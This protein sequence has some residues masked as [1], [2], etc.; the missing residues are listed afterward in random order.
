MKHGREAV[1]PILIFSV[2]FWRRETDRFLLEKVVELVTDEYVWFLEFV[3]E[4]PDCGTRESLRL[5]KH[6]NIELQLVQ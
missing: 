6:V 3:L 4:Q 2:L 1:H 5:D